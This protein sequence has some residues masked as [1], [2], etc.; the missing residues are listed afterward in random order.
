[1]ISLFDGRFH[2]TWGRR[3]WELQA[4][5]RNLGYRLWSGPPFLTRAEARRG[6][7]AWR[8]FDFLHNVRAVN[9]RT[10]ERL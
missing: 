1:M 2:I 4:T 6:L 10:G 5:E 8:Y 3:E 9:V 7:R